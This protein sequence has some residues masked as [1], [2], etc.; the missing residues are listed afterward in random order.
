[1]SVV[2]TKERAT[3]AP[4]QPPTQSS[5][6]S[7]VDLAAASAQVPS[8][9]AAVRRIPFWASASVAINGLMLLSISLMYW[10]PDLM[11]IQSSIA[12]DQVTP[13]DVVEEA[14]AGPEGNREQLSY[15]EWLKVLAKEAKATALNQPDRLT[16]LLGDSLSLWFPPELLPKGRSWLNQGISGENSA[17]L[18]KRLNLLDE[19]QPQTILLMVGVNDLIKGLSDE[20]VL[21]NYKQIIQALKQKHPKTEIVMQSLLPH[22]GDRLSVEDKEPVAQVSNERIYQ[23]NQKLSLLSAENEVYFLNLHPLFADGDGLLRQELATDGLHLN[24]QGYLAWRSGLQVFDQLLLKQ[25]ETK[26]AAIGE[27]K[28][29]EAKSEVAPPSA[30]APSE[31]PAEKPEAK[32]VEAPAVPEEPAQ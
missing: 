15:D 16:V 19:L 4:T 11:G 5:P 23:F 26:P 9:P 29:E 22:G 30:T 28:S 14:P 18:L 1:M 27:A 20:Q 31:T 8:Q 13:A 21:D 2:K 24:E 10:Q 6:S 25:P 17:G 32:P 7:Q 3:S 12:P